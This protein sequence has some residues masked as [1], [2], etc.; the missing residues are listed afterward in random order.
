MHFAVG[1]KQTFDLNK[2]TK[3]NQVSKMLIKSVLFVGVIAS[4][5]SSISAQCSSSTGDCLAVRKLWEGLKQ[6][7]TTKNGCS[8]S[9]VTV[10]K[11]RVTRM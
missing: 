1:N 6:V 7:T 9:G 2:A 8:L 3:A 4:L 10:S 11:C 5:V